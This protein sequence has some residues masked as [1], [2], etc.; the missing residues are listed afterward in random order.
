MKR[1]LSFDED[2]PE[3]TEEQLKEFH[4]VAETSRGEESSGGGLGKGKQND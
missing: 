1:E 4:R 3:L 2:N